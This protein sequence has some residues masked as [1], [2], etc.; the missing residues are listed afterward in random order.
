MSKLSR[1]S[2]EFR[3]RAVGLLFDQQNVFMDVHDYLKKYLSNNNK[4]KRCAE[5]NVHIRTFCVNRVNFS[6]AQ[7]YQL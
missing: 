1:Y 7:H 6:R 4:R 3:E 2:P 5:V